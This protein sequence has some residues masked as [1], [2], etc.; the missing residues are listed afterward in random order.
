MIII[1]DVLMSNL[2][3]TR[4]SKRYLKREPRTIGE[5]VQDLRDIN[6]GRFD[7]HTSFCQSCASCCG[8]CFFLEYDNRTKR[9]SCVIWKL[10][11]RYPIRRYDYRKLPSLTKVRKELDYIIKRSK[12]NHQDKM[13]SGFICDKIK[14]IRFIDKRKIA[15]GFNSK[16]R[17]REIK[18]IERKRS[19]LNKILREFN[20][21]V[22]GD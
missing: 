20:L 19:K 1:G 8:E 18:H 3:R 17:K 22:I 16:E 2:I 13:C 21:K 10:K 5:V 6:G 7:I 11:A 12:E 4:T 14:S 9:F 15:I